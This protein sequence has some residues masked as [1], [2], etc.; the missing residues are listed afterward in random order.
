MK[1]NE[2]IMATLEQLRHSHGSMLLYEGVELISISRR[3]GHASLAITM[4]VYVHEID[5]MK[6]RDDKQITKA[7]NALAYF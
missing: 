5:E 7:L 2:E 4:K 3:L 1:T 6:Q